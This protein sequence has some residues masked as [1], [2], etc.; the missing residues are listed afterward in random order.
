[1]PNQHK[2]QLVQQIK[3][4]LGL[5]KSVII[6]DYS[7]TDANEQVELRSMINEV[8]G[9]MFVTKNSLINIAL[10]KDELAEALSGM[11]ALV[12]SYEDAVSAVKKLFEF[13]DEHEK[14]EIKMGLMTDNDT[15]LTR[16]KVVHLSKLPSKEELVVTLIQRIKG[17]AYGLVNALSDNQRKLVYALQAIADQKQEAG[18]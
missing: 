14:L 18:A 16:E 13:K 7:G 3:D 17:P 6:V 4:K 5:A 10:S 8:G 1:M 12:F 11:N 15:V 2:K 9:E